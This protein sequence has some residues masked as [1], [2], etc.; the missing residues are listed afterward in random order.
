MTKIVRVNW[1]AFKLAFRLLVRSGV[2][3][4]QAYW[5]FATASMAMMQVASCLHREAPG[6]EFCGAVIPC[7]PRIFPGT[8]GIP[9]CG[10]PAIAD[11]PKQAGRDACAPG[12]LSSF[13][14]DILF[15]AP[16][17]SNF[18]HA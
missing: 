5:R 2:N 4:V 8:A 15:G 6:S 10:F 18:T 13:R 3:S 9:A 7:P 17:A 11:S 14:G 1:T 16:C 12:G